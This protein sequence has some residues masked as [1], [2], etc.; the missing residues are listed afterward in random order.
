MTIE[1]FKTPFQMRLDNEN[2]WVKLGKSMPWDT[3]AKIYYRSMSADK[4]APA[5]DAR[6][7]TGAMIIKHKLKLD[8]RETIETIREN[9]YMQYF[10]GLSEYT[11]E[12]V[13]ER[14]LFTALRYRLGA[15]KFDVMTRQIILRSEKKEDAA[16]KDLND[17][18]NE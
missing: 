12:G 3:L 16:E 9:M 4:G 13:F 6:I 7:V 17:P 5:I 14:S 18:D 15:D 10:P 1:E 11:Y 2:R 8:D